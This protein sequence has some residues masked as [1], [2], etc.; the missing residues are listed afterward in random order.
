MFV[1]HIG[2]Q[3]PSPPNSSP[4]VAR[5]RPTFHAINTINGASS[6]SSSRQAPEP[7]IIPEPGRPGELQDRDF[8]VESVVGW[9]ED[10]SENELQYEIQW[11]QCRIPPHLI[12]TDAESKSFVYCA[13]RKWYIRR[14]VDNRDADVWDVAWDVSWRHYEDLS[15]AAESIDK[16]ES[17]HQEG[18]S[19]RQRHVHHD[20]LPYGPDRLYPGGHLP[21]GEV[22]PPGLPHGE[23][24]WYFHPEPGKD[25]AR[26]AMKSIQA[27]HPHGSPQSHVVRYL[28]RETK[29]AL[30]FRPGYTSRAAF[31]RREQRNGALLVIKGALQPRACNRCRDG[32]GPFPY[33]VTLAG[34]GNGACA[35]CMWDMEGKRC[36]WHENPDAFVESFHAIAVFL[37]KEG[38][39]IDLT[40]SVTRDAGDGVDPL[41]PNDDPITANHSASIRDHLDDD[42]EARS[43]KDAENLWPTGGG[44]DDD[45]G[46][47]DDAAEDHDS[48]YQ[49]QS[50]PSVTPPRARHSAEYLASSTPATETS[51][52]VP[53]SNDLVDDDDDW[54]TPELFAGHSSPR[55]DHHCASHASTELEGALSSRD[56]GSGTVSSHGNVRGEN[57]AVVASSLNASVH[58]SAK[59]SQPP[60]RPHRPSVAHGRA[61]SSTQRVSPA[62]PPSAYH[63]NA[64]TTAESALDP[65]HTAPLHSLNDSALNKRAGK[66]PIRPQQSLGKRQRVQEEEV[67]RVFETPLAKR[68]A[69]AATAMGSVGTT[70]SVPAP[71]SS[72]AV[73]SASS[74]SSPSTSEPPTLDP[75]TLNPLTSNPFPSPA[76]TTSPPPTPSTTVVYRTHRFLP[77]EATTPQV[78]YIL[79]LCR[80]RSP[81]WHGRLQ[82]IWERFQRHARE[83]S[84]RTA[85]AAF[86][87]ITMEEALSGYAETVLNEAVAAC[88][89]VEPRQG[90]GE[91]KVVIVIDD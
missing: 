66:Q 36:N 81:D 32:K 27:L 34:F 72:T 53:V 19:P 63:Q 9:R 88:C 26:A 84:A 1:A 50:S 18:A 54:D 15:D 57:D 56:I 10:G 25:Y 40:A 91:E 31:H 20:H 49:P 35:N 7:K 59:H 44:F 62:Q 80:A 83:Q 52:R 13:G 22:P 28:L 14:V 61:S 23:A 69:A 55:A 86:T 76:K 87:E 58:Q 77:N 39:T 45:D 3:Q 30:Q 33:C 68:T 43:N 65:T 29:R 24:T 8:R 75:S 51:S 37:P 82:A 47:T 41:A 70:S 4:D 38:I 67:D 42:H 90:G 17:G 2:L 85:G 89:P 12:E 74:A 64:S 5:P 48:D 21:L 46:D 71:A 73:L 78:R 6:S 16:Y 60:Q 79:D 11:A